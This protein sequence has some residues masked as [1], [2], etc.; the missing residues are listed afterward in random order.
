MDSGCVGVNMDDLCLI[1][2]RGKSV[3]V[4]TVGIKNGN[5]DIKSFYICSLRESLLLKSKE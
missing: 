5:L 1:M 2:V 4:E 3:Y